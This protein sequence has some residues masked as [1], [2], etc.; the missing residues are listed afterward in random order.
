MK[1]YS[2]VVALSEKAVSLV[3]EMYKGE[4]LWAKANVVYNI[5]TGKYDICFHPKHSL[6]FPEDYHN[7]ILEHC[8]QRI[9]VINE[10]P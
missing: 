5:A 10:E 1:F 7:D 4:D 8:K 9:K 2:K 3:V 6:L